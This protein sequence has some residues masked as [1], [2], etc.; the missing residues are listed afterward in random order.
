MRI[1]VV[2]AILIVVAVMAGVLLILALNESKNGPTN[3]QNG[4][5]QLDESL[6][7]G[8]WGLKRE[9]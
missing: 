2:G 8:L 9:R 4:V 3:Q 7:Q 6:R 5:S 1:T